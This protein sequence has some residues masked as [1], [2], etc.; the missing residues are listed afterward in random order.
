MLGRSRARSAEVTMK[1]PP[2]SK[3]MFECLARNGVDNIFEAMTSSIVSGFLKKALGLSSAHAQQLIIPIGSQA[4][5]EI[6]KPSKGMD[7][8]TVLSGFGEPLQ[9]RNPV[10][11]PP[12]TRWQYEHF[13]VYFESEFLNE[14]NRQI[15]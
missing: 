1:A 14:L 3:S 8:N 7:M 13:S 12:I 4:K 5:L 6:L 11:E 10:G 15:N 2:P 9:R